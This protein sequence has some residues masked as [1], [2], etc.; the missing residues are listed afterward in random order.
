MEG[1]IVAFNITKRNTKNPDYMAI[2]TLVFTLPTMASVGLS[3]EKG[4][5]KGFEFTVNKNSVQEWFSAKRVNEKI[6]AY[7]TLIE[8]ETGKNPWCSFNW[9]TC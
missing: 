5:E 2:P 8:K 4:T 7:K 6:Y 3:E 9:T 1:H